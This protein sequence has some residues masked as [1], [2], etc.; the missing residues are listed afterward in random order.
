MK[1][2]LA[3]T[4][5]GQPFTS[6]NWT[7]KPGNEEEFI[8]RWTEFTSWAQREAS[9]AQGFVLIRHMDDPRQFV[10]F[11]SWES[12]DAVD[13]WRSTPEF[14]QYLGA[15]REVCDEFRPADSTVAAVVAP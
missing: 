3:M 8:R 15:C 13:R 5:V 1:E 6:G 14:V 2:A 9:G 10:S 11:G 7:V 4:N 12:K